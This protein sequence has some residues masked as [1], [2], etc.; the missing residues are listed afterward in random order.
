MAKIKK[1]DSAKA[2]FDML[3]FQYKP[4]ERKVL[5]QLKEYKREDLIKQ[6]K[7]CS[8]AR[9]IAILDGMAQKFGL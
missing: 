7:S 2:V 3:A 6:Y 9:K 5:A 1:T 4:L 8:Y